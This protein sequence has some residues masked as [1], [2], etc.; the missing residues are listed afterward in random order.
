[1][2][3]FCLF[4]TDG[5]CSIMRLQDDADL[6]RNVQKWV[7]ANPRF[8]LAGDPVE[9]QEADI[10]ARTFRDAWQP[11]G[12][13]ID[14]DMPKARAIHLDR[15]RE[16]RDAEL[17]KADNDLKRAEDTADAA[18]VTRIRTLRQTLRDIPQSFDLD[19]AATPEDLDA[20]WPA[21][22][23]ARTP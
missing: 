10:P 15:I 1:M 2:R 23:P 12:S 13:K 18:E 7:A 21:E 11:N 4:R 17:V 22:L 8:T 3:I 20:L 6:D 14:I 9:I 16:A 19:R 5:G